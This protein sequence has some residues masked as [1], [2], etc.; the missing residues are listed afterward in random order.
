MS[1]KKLTNREI[2]D[3]LGKLSQNDQVLWKEILEIKQLF[4][5]Y[6]EYRNKT[7]K[8]QQNEFNDFVRTKVEEFE[9]QQLKD[10]T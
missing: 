4:S 7:H 6:L 9:R 8:E 5:L 3:T 10:K 2:T 1:K